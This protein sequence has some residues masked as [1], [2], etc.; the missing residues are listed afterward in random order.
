M[1][2]FGQRII[3]KCCTFHV[4]LPAQISE[5]SSSSEK[6]KIFLVDDDLNFASK[7]KMELEADNQY[8]V[9]IVSDPSTALENYVKGLYDPCHS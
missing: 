2:G 6:T 4:L 7:V 1:E 3:K 9:D 5:L 8:E